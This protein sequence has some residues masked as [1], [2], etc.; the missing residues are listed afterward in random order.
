[1]LLQGAVNRNRLL[2]LRPAG[3][4]QVVEVGRSLGPTGI[5]STFAILQRA[6]SAI[7][8]CGEAGEAYQYLLRT[9]DIRQTQFIVRLGS[10][11]RFPIQIIR[12]GLKV[13]LTCL[14]KRV[15]IKNSEQRR[16]GCPPSPLEEIVERCTKRTS[17]ARR[18]CQRA[19]RSENMLE[20]GGNEKP[21]SS[22]AA[23]VAPA[24]HTSILPRSR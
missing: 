21:S 4:Q 22:P 12:A 19:A 14:I 6:W 10:A 18:C 16:T 20:A 8:E 9:G 23:K 2:R 13:W 15:A 3:G 11:C 7:A 5:L 17:T 1:V 24:P